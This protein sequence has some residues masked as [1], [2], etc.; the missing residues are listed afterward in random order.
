MVVVTMKWRFR[1]DSQAVVVML[2]VDGGAGA[3]G[4]NGEVVELEEEGE[5]FADEGGRGAQQ[6]WRR[7]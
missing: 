1:R 4:G 6:K 5:G 7:D 3:R 2:E